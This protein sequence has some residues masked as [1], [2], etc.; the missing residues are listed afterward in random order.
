ML[1]I[2]WGKIVKKYLL[3][4]GFYATIKSAIL[5]KQNNERHMES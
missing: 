3:R 1:L 4:I 5:L 2:N